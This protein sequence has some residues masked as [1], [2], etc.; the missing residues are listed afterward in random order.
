VH[1][2]LSILTSFSLFIAPEGHASAQPT[3]GPPQ[4]QFKHLPSFQQH[5]S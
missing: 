5:F 3:Q 1:I 4:E 2:V